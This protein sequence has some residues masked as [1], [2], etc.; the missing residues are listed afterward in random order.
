V[1][2]D[3]SGS[4]IRRG[5]GFFEDGKGARHCYRGR[6]YGYTLSSDPKNINTG[7]SY[8]AVDMLKAEKKKTDVGNTG[9]PFKV[10]VP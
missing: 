6:T 5:S 4:P 3:G 9:G 7:V 2:C 10:L 8:A 1:L